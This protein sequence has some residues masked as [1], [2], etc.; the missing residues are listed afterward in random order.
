MSHTI[1]PEGFALANL[2]FDAQPRLLIGDNSQQPQ[3]KTNRMDL[4]TCARR[5]Y[6]ALVA[7]FPVKFALNTAPPNEAV[8]NIHP[9]DEVLVY[10]EKKGW[11][12]PYTYLYR[13]G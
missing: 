11:D 13:D 4:M 9:G 10:R 12:G 6:E 2:A 3:T 5:E 7:A 8:V 1:G